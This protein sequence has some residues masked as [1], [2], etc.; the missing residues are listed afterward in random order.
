M[1]KPGQ[2][3]SGLI[4]ALVWLTAHYGRAR[5]A[6]VLAAGLPVEDKGMTPQLFCEAATRA[7]LRARIVKKSPADINDA[8]LPA[9]VLT[10]TRGAVVLV[11]RTGDTVRIIDGGVESTIE[12]NALDKRANGYAIYVRPAEEGAADAEQSHWFWPAINEGAGVYAQVA[13]AT[14]FINLFALTSPLFMM[15]FYNR[16]LPNNAV[17]TGWVL[18]IGALVVFGFDFIIKTLR[19]YFIDI[20]GRRADVVV[21][22][23]IYDQ[24]LDVRLGQ[25]RDSIG[26]S[27]SM[28]RD[29]DGVRD[30][31]TSATLSVIIDLPFSLLFVAAIWWVAGPSMAL[32][33]LLIYV[34]AMAVGWLTQ[35][36]VKRSV[37]KA[38]M[39]AE[40]K[41]GLLVETMAAQETVRGLG[42]EGVL[43]GRYRRYLASAAE[44]G[45]VSRFY[46]G[47]SVN[48]SGLMQAGSGVV[49]VLIGMYMVAARDM[50]S[51][52]LIACMMLSSRA[53][54]PVGAVAAL[55]NKYHQARASYRRIDELMKQD[56]ERGG[57]RNFLHRPDLRGAFSMQNVDFAYPDSNVKTL[58]G[59]S[60]NIAAGERVAI[61]GRIG[62]GKSSLV[63]LLVNF[64]QPA[65]GAVLV[66]GTDMRQIDPADLRRHVAYMGQDTTLIS[67]SIRDNIALARHDASDADIL[68]VAE[69]TGVHDFVR[70]HPQGYDAAVGEGGQGLSGGQRQAVALART[71][72]RDTPVL[73]LDEPTNAMDGGSE[74]RLLQKLEPYLANK[75]FILVTHKPALLRLVNRLIVV[76]NGRVVMDGARDQV[77]QALAQGQV[78][79]IPG[80]GG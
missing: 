12:A 64:Y 44:A 24:L 36:P 2:T 25:R 16:V 65:A 17:E 3:D 72:L 75:T 5:S 35:L 11:T 21:G 1:T 14:V 42:A 8:V 39:A 19:G 31:L 66:D 73:V 32:V 76:D 55:L 54:A 60:L 56:T 48:F 38:L 29:F 9:V 52:A 23:K 80:A 78:A 69:M 34:L 79:A 28:L 6:S 67:G 4:D 13:L 7:G 37:R 40:K 27:A 57:T 22:Q 26:A 58:S 49:L 10:A 30:F 50:T 20:A 61:V 45:Q 77:W 59:V 51:G 70:R 41:H 68:R 46:S 53:I 71:L 43:R 15:N 18:A 33:L 47:L 74:E 62:S 63:K